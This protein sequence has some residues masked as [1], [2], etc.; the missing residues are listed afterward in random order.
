MSMEVCLTES[1]GLKTLKEN[2][3][4]ENSYHV[5]Q[6]TSKQTTLNTAANPENLTLQ[7]QVVGAPV[8]SSSPLQNHIR[9]RP[10]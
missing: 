4:K 6:T 9:D 7:P 3:L 5:E 2:T 10:Y 1:M 8:A